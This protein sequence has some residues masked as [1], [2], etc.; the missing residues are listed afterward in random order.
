[1][2]SGQTNGAINNLRGTGSLV[3]DSNGGLTVISDADP[4]GDL[5]STS[6]GEVFSMSGSN[7]GNLLNNAGVTWG[8]F[9][10][11]FDLTITN[12]NGTSGCK[13]S[14]TSIIT[15]VTKADYIPHHQ[16]F[17]Y[18]AST[19][20]LMHTRPA[21]VSEVGHSGPANHQYDTHDFFD[22]VNAGNFPAVSFLKAPGYQDGHAGYSDPLDEQTFIV[23][24]ISFL[25]KGRSGRARR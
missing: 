17:Q 6:T 16:P 12:S 25:M 23:N 9:Q 22:A 7:I 14:T 21:S 3:S 4:N 10:G 19:A 18:Y 20:N 2:I 13:R 5:C 15:G 8:F 24:T 11:G 1:L